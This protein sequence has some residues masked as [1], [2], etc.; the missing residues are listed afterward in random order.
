MNHAALSPL[1]FAVIIDVLPENLR[2]EQLWEV[3]FA[4]DLAIIADSEKQ[5]QDRLLK[6]QESLEKYGLKMNAKKTATMVCSKNGD[7]QV[8]IKDAHGEDY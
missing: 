6:W 8:N 5:Q 7:E 1:L 2:A 4:N 3:L